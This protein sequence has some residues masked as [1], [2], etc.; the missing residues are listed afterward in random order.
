MRKW[1]QT[2]ELRT[3]RYRE[4]CIKADEL[5]AKYTARQQELGEHG[6]S[7][8]FRPEDPRC[9]LDFAYWL[10]PDGCYWTDGTS[11]YQLD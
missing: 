10:G 2:E 3:R 5:A 11:T 8:R 7:I 1:W 6:I 9:R 4:E